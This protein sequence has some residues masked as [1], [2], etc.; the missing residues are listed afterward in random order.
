[1]A[2]IAVTRWHDRHR[3][4]AGGFGAVVADRR[5]GG[6]AVDVD[7][8]AAHSSSLTVSG[9]GYGWAH[10]GETCRLVTAV[11]LAST[12]CF[13]AGGYTHFDTRP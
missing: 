8:T 3:R 1:M 6:S 7:E 2:T 4:A 11:G 5:A 10:R 12:A 9:G 13:D